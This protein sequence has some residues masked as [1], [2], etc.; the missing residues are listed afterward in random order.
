LNEPLMKIPL[1]K[2]NGHGDEIQVD[3]SVYLGQLPPDV[4]QVELYCTAEKSGG[5]NPKAIPLK[6]ISSNGDG[7]SHYCL[8]AATPFMDRASIISACCQKPRPPH[9][10]T[11][12]G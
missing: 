3:A 11:S 7:V 1:P 8:T 12:W 6:M 9:T 4:V 2:S 5:K 10:N